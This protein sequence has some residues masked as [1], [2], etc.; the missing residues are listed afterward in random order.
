ML[1]GRLCKFSNRDKS[2]PLHL[3][4][5][6]YQELRSKEFIS[7]FKD[8][9]IFASISKLRMVRN[10]ICIHLGKCYKTALALMMILLMLQKMKSDFGKQMHD[11]QE[12]G[13]GSLFTHTIIA[14]RKELCIF[15]RHQCGGRAGRHFFSAT[16]SIQT[17]LIR[18]THIGKLSETMSN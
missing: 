11:V 18:V 13:L 6:G 15:R 4:I 3:K 2:D 12:E 5:K 7:Y 16:I 10:C 17:V 8:S 9:I 14:K 1:L